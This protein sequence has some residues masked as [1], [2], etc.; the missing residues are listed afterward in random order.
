MS[1]GG[2]PG[3]GTVGVSL[4]DKQ[5]SVEIEP[6]EESG[7]AT[8]E[9]IRTNGLLQAQSPTHKTSHERVHRTGGSFYITHANWHM[10]HMLNIYCNLANTYL[11]WL[12]NEISHHIIIS[13]L[14]ITCRML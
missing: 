9:N 12:L 3:Q 6:V 8:V 4:Q 2:T 13:F 7:P 10:L 11:L 5:I 14:F 1:P